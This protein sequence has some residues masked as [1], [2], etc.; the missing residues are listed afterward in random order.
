MRLKD[1]CNDYSD[2]D[3]PCD[4][5]IRSV[6]EEKIVS[7]EDYKKELINKKE[8][9]IFNKI[10]KIKYK[11]NETL[12]N[13]YFNAI[14]FLIQELGGLSVTNTV[15]STLLKKI[16]KNKKYSKINK[17]LNFLSDAIPV[18][19]TTYKIAKTLS[20]FLSRTKK[21]DCVD[22]EMLYKKK[23]MG[24]EHS[25][26]YLDDYDFSLGKEIVLWLLKKPK[27]DLFKVVSFYN[28]KYEQIDFI[29]IKEFGTF[30]I[31]IVN[32]E[33]ISLIIKS[34][35][36]F[37]S[38]NA[39][40]RNTYAYI[41]N[42]KYGDLVNLKECIMKEFVYN[43]S[44]DKNIVYYNTNG[45][46]SREK[47]K[48]DYT[49]NQFNVDIFIVEIKNSFK[50]NKKRGYI[51]CGPAGTGKSS[52]LHE[53]ENKINDV[54]FIYVA[55]NVLSHVDDISAFFDFIRLI[56]PCIVVFEDMDANSYLQNKNSETVGYFLDNI[57]A[58]NEENSD[59]IF[60]ATINDSS[61]VNST[62][63]N[64]RGRFDKVFYVGEPKH[65]EDIYSI[66]N[67]RYKR[68]MKKDLPIKNINKNIYKTII[69]NRFTQSDI[70]EVI[71]NLIIM[72]INIDNEN[73]MKSVQELLNSKA[74]LKKTYKITEKID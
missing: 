23:I 10:N 72:D 31:H 56:K 65:H 47:N 9:G 28:Y 12:D 71:D 1:K 13:K 74:A 42:N 35:I 2:I 32:N 54:P 62:L 49:I 25:D 68:E 64:R 27:S 59:I 38:E 46:S 60:I 45:L 58:V 18:G 67:V 52:I 41:E 57:D 33:D 66:M 22:Y 44:I 20:T 37:N 16:N 70:C 15:I 34:D 5:P 43:L 63:I 17:T 14:N 55:P 19:L 50:L 48:I 8:K 11:I 61:L 21:N 73:L 39:F 24:I 53:I 26:I 7:Y 36:L 4:K 40:V 69:K 51:F 6:K 3:E 30:Y 29:D